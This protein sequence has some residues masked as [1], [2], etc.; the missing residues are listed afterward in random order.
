MIHFQKRDIDLN[1]VATDYTICLKELQNFTEGNFGPRLKMFFETVKQE[2]QPNKYSYKNIYITSIGDY[3]TQK[4]KCT[5]RLKEIS[6]TLICKLE[7]RYVKL[8]SLLNFTCLNIET[9]QKLKSQHIESF[10]TKM[11][12]ELIKHYNLNFKKDDDMKTKLFPESA[13]LEEFKKFKTM[14]STEWTKLEPDQIYEKIEKSQHFI[15]IKRLIKIYRSLPLSSVECERVFSSVNRIKNE[16]RNRLEDETL[17]DLLMI[18][19]N[20]IDIKD[21]DFQESFQRWKSEKKRYFI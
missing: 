4:K 13:V 17:D 20:G 9:V 16:M 6:K 1:S 2:S 10:G 7:K 3:E 15:Y 19:S 11:M 14:V 12:T 21:F 5:D 18:S 8:P